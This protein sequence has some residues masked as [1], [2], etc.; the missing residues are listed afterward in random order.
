MHLE[1]RSKLL[2]FG[3]REEDSQTYHRLDQVVIPFR[4][5]EILLQNCSK[6]LKSFFGYFKGWKCHHSIYHIGLV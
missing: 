4:V 1:I 5:N 3:S 6:R 2:S